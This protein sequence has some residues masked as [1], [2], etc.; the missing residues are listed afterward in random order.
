MPDDSLLDQFCGY[1]SFS[2]P[3]KSPNCLKLALWTPLLH[4]FESPSNCFR[5]SEECIYFGVFMRQ[6]IP[7]DFATFSQFS[8]MYSLAHGFGTRNGSPNSCRAQPYLSIK[9]PVAPR[10][11]LWAVQRRTMARIWTSF[12]GYGSFEICS[13]KWAKR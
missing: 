7:G 8:L 9:R 2:R 6:P 13:K 5:R 12:D 1:R 3:K 4:V 10:S 11:N